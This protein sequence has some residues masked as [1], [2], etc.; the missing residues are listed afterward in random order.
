MYTLSIETSGPYTSCVIAQDDKLKYFIISFKRF[1]HAEDL[2][3]LVH[4]LM[5]LENISWED[6]ENILVSL[7]PGFF[8]SL[9]VGISFVKAISIVHP[10]KIYGM[11]TLDVLAFIYNEEKVIPTLPA[12]KGEV[13]WAAYR[14]GKRISEYAISKVENIK[15]KYLDFKVYDPV[16]YPDARELMEFFI[17]NRNTLKPF[18]PKDLEP[19]YLR[20]PDAYLKHNPSK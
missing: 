9:R 7:G 20:L 4:K 14:R 8:T 10:I 12:Q 19:F 16:R 13:F 1:H 11:V 2:N 17:K 5:E 15:E 18:D 3:L 6:I